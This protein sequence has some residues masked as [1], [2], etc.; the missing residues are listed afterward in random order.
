M[1]ITI[2]VRQPT[3]LR[4]IYFLLLNTFKPRWVP[5]I[6]KHTVVSCI[7]HTG[8]VH[9]GFAAATGIWLAYAI[10]LLLG[11]QKS[12]YLWITVAAAA[13]LLLSLV[14]LF[15]TALPQTR[16]QHHDAFE[17]MHRFVGWLCLATAW[18]IVVMFDNYDESTSEWHFHMSNFLKAFEFWASCVIT[19]FI[20]LPWATYVH[21]VPVECVVESKNIVTLKFEGGSQVASVSTSFRH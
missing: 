9:S 11:H 15:C 6:V 1:L 13:L 18:V 17:F 5:L 16:R 20:V 8:G 19:F 3:V 21:K 4:C 2:L 12:A 10:A 7:W 14:L